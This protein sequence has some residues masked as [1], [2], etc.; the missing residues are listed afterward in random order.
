M[1]VK[2]RIAYEIITTEC[3][4]IDVVLYVLNNIVFITLFNLQTRSLLHNKT[5]Q[6]KK[7][8]ANI[9]RA[10]VKSIESIASIQ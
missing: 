1:N 3:P 2:V 5:G 7:D 8:Y 6:Y 4:L 9:P 10:S